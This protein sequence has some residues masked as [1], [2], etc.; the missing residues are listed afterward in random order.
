MN[1]PGLVNAHSH[2]FQRILRGRTQFR[3]SVAAASNFW[4]WR[5]LM[6]QACAALGPEEIYIASRQ[7][8]IEMALAG[9]TS[10]GE[11]HYLHRDPVGNE[12]ADRNELANQVIRAAREVGLRI[13]LL[14]V[15]YARSGYRV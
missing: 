8:F 3:V 9:I 10:V 4:S 14:R 13:A 1:L 2:A 15:G 5:E 11:F 6:Y 7:A 12:Y